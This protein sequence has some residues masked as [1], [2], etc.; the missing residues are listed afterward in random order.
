MT[1]AFQTDAFQN[2]AFQIDT[3]PPPVS[4]FYA[5]ETGAGGLN[6]YDPS[7][8]LEYTRR[9]KKSQETRAEFEKRQREEKEEVALLV[10][11]AYNK[12]LGIE[13]PPEAVP[14]IPAELPNK[15][16]EA[17]IARTVRDL[18]NEIGLKVSLQQIGALVRLRK[19]EAM[20]EAHR[21]D[22]EARVN[23]LL[24]AEAEE[25]AQMDAM[26]DEAEK[27]FRAVQDMLK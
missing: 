24:A 5:D 7:V 23:M 22:V 20:A 11:R 27:M 6:V 17:Q 21:R 12:A 26:M 14:E 25:E 10:A 16:I 9:V 15:D 1:T 3:G 13:E 18:A 19:A 8:Q 2:N 4:Q